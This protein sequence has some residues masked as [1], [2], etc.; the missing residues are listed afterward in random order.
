MPLPLRLVLVTLLAL[1]V[2]A[3]A[4]GRLEN[5][6]VDPG[7]PPTPYT[8]LLVLGMA[9][10]ESVR[11]AYEDSFVATL[12]AHGVKARAGHNLLPDGGLADVNTVRRAVRS[13]GAD[14]ILI[15][16]LA[17][18]TAESAQ[19]PQRHYVTTGLYG[20]LYPY[21]GLVYD[22]VTEPGY[23]ARFKL[24]AFETNLYDAKR[25]RLVWSG[26]SPKLDPSSEQ[27]T[28]GE[29]IEKVA[30]AL[31]AAG[32]IPQATASSRS[33]TPSSVFH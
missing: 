19:V 5:T 3:C 8:N 26:R 2:V 21:Y 13:A 9:E 28:L 32:L 4:S 31:A 16:H 17:G 23:Y 11:V 10:K 7:R 33:P 14:G 18:V 24:L 20:G 1:S 30:D 25:E 27:T 15:T 22:N 12:K 6:W 29:V